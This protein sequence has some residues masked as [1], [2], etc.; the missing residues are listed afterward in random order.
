[1]SQSR[2]KFRDPFAARYSSRS[3]TNT[4]D[5]I[6]FASRAPYSQSAHILSD[7][8]EYAGRCAIIVESLDR[9]SDSR[10]TH[11]IVTTLRCMTVPLVF[12]R[13]RWFTRSLEF[14]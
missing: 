5:E 14:R 1:M 2:I 6:A 13:C 10:P 4:R 12:I 11:P 9:D 7:R 8:L 3:A